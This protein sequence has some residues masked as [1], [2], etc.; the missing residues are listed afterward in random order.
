M[1]KLNI[2]HLEKKNGKRELRELKIRYRNLPLY[3][4]TFLSIVLIKSFTNEPTALLTNFTI[5]SPPL[6]LPCPCLPLALNP[7]TF[8]YMFEFEQN[9]PGQLN[10]LL[11]HMFDGNNI[12]LMV[13]VNGEKGKV[14]I[15]RHSWVLGIL[16]NSGST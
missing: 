11:I 3:K 9:L 1:V 15:R 16:E 13:G 2:S 6:S 12:S 10:A 8:T 7:Y 14:N 4:R 5:H